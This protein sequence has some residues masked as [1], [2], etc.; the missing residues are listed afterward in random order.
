MSIMICQFIGASAA[1]C[2]SGDPIQMVTFTECRSINAA[3]HTPM[4]RHHA[5]RGRGVG[6]RVGSIMPIGR[7]TITFFIIR[8][9]AKSESR[10]QS[11][12]AR[13]ER[14]LNSNSCCFASPQVEQSR[15]TAAA[16]RLL[17]KIRQDLASFS[18]LGD[19]QNWSAADS[20]LYEPLQSRNVLQPRLL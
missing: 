14:K 5:K 13:N 17:R 7:F 19:Q 16:L 3:A 10:R 8:D 11:S 12:D 6:V 20:S 1:P 4:L 9:I 18:I 15:C 2:G